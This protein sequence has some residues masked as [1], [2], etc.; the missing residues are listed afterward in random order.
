MCKS[1][2][3]SIAAVVAFVLTVGAEAAAAQGRSDKGP[4]WGRGGPS[5]G[6]TFQTPLGAP[7]GG[8]TKSH[9]TG[10]WSGG[11]WGGGGQPSTTFETPSGPPSSGS[12]KTHTTGKQ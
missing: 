12:T 4:G 8:E 3:L 5:S 11:N 7:S 6:T 10:G 2:C 9:T 1:Y